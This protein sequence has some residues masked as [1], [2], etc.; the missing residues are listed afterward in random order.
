MTPEELGEIRTEIL[1]LT[2]IQ[3]IQDGR[4][5]ELGKLIDEMK[6][7]MGVNIEDVSSTSDMVKARVVYFVNEKFRHLSD[8]DPSFAS[9][10]KEILDAYERS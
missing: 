3:Q 6:R 2:V 5:L 9:W 4:L 8:E 1:R 10:L 7:S